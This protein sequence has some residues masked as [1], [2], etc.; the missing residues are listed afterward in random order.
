MKNVVRNTKEL[1]VHDIICEKVHSLSQ[2]RKDVQTSVNLMAVAAY[3]K[4]YFLKFLEVIRIRTT[5]FTFLAT[6]ELVILRV[7]NICK[8]EISTICLSIGNHSPLLRSSR[9]ANVFKANQELH[10]KQKY[11]AYNIAPSSKLP[12]WIWIFCVHFALWAAHSAVW[13]TTVPH[14]R[15]HIKASGLFY[16]GFWSPLRSHWCTFRRYR[17]IIWQICSSHLNEGSCK[18][19]W[20]TMFPKLWSENCFKFNAISCLWPVTK[21]HPLSA[22]RNMQVIQ[23]LPAVC[24]CA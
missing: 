3:W 22:K 15:K 13:Y 9:F 16:S 19:A 20:C 17:T 21:D 18:D 4:V 23:V 12:N 2:L 10:L 6:V 11:W 1:E 5:V 14:V 8:D 24:E 7:S